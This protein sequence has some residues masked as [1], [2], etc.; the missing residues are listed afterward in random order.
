[1]PDIRYHETRFPYDSKREILWKALW[2]GYFR[3]LVRAGDTVLELGA[4][5]AHFINQ[6][7]AAR[8][9]ALDTWPGLSNYTAAGVEVRIGGAEDLG[10]LDDNSIDFAFASNLFEHL[11]Q[12]DFAAVLNQLARKLKPSGCLTI[13]QPNY[14]YAY[15]EYFDDYTHVTVYSDVS[16]C[17]FLAA[18]GF[19]VI[20]AK[21]GFL[22]LTVKSRW[23]IHP[24]LIRLYIAS[25]VKPMAK[26]MLI[27]AVPVPRGEI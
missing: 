21:P 14:R 13:L 3:R 17:D 1:M 7:R 23:P 20:D 25:P 15:R 6:V 11:S 2:D 10:F 5:Y 26:Q 24:W 18:H 4:G 22:P 8:R 16:I 19:R 9:I 27:R 12:N